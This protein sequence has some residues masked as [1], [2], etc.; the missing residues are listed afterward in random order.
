[1]LKKV[2]YLN[3]IIMYQLLRIQQL[4][5]VHTLADLS[6]VKA[7]PE[8]TISFSDAPYER[9]IVVGNIIYS[10]KSTM[11]LRSSNIHLYR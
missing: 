6:M 8:C 1:M 4:S 3:L 9:I 2:I 5:G 10:L 7:N 11:F